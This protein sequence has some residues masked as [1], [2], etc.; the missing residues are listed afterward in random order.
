M[1]FDFKYDDFFDWVDTDGE[2]YEWTAKDG[3]PERIIKQLEKIKQA[4][5]KLNVEEN[6]TIID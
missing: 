4:Y 2:Y 5:A 6:L 3:A 1:Q